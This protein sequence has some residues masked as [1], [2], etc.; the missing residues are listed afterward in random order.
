MPTGIELQNSEYSDTRTDWGKR[1]LPEIY[2]LI[3]SI[4]FKK[5]D[6]SFF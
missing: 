1:R 2:E 6:S 3:L 4:I 5:I